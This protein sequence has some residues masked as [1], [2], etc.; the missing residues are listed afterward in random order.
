MSKPTHTIKAKV[1]LYHM[2][3]STSGTHSSGQAG[4][5]HF[6]TLPKKQSAEIKKTYAAMK[7]GWGSLPV[8][9][10]VGK[11]SWKTSIFPDS[12][13]GAYLLPLKA[14]VRKKENIKDGDVITFKL[15]VR[16]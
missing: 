6:V 11:T 8:T 7:R 13:A 3:P 12:K 5:W 15:E 14:L 10:T 1:W 4:A 9:I 16:L 2:N